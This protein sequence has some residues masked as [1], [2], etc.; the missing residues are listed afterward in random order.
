MLYSELLKQKRPCPFC[1]PGE[2]VFEAKGA[3]YLTYSV[4]PYTKFHLL[5]IPKRHDASFEKLTAAEWQDI[6]AML[7]VGV[8]VLRRKGITD[9][10]IIMRNGSAAGRSVQHPHVHIVPKHSIGDLDRKGSARRVMSVKAIAA[11]S[12]EVAKLLKKKR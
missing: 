3:A 12:T 8:E 1:S 5:V 7:T 9:Y 2:R 10:T 6:H 11:M 4:A